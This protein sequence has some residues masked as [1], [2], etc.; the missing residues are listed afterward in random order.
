MEDDIFQRFQKKTGDKHIY[1]ALVGCHN[2]VNSTKI[3]TVYFSACVY[4][5]ACVYVPVRS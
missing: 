4:T 1:V 3:R 5:Y 2:K